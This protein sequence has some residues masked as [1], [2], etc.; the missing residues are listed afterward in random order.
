MNFVRR[1]IA[2]LKR[3]KIKK[4]I[5]IILEIH[6]I[7]SGKGEKIPLLQKRDVKETFQKSKENCLDYI[8]FIEKHQLENEKKQIIPLFEETEDLLYPKQMLDRELEKANKQYDDIYSI[9]N[10]AGEKLL[11]LRRKSVNLIEKVEKLVSSI[12]MSAKKFDKDFEEIKI[13]K[14]KFKGALEYGQEQQKALVRSAR[15]VGTGVTAGIAVA[16]IS[17]KVAMWVATTFGKASTGT[18]I[19]ALS[20]AVAKN[21]A[22]S[23]LGGGAVAAGGGGMVAGKALLALSGPIGWAVSGAS[24]LVSILNLVRKYYNANK[25]KRD[26]IIHMKNYI[27]SLKELK[28]NIDH[29]SKKTAEQLKVVR[30]QCSC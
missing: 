5:G 21:A 15:G 22:L 28:E 10:N 6:K 1:I 11:E 23:W 17:P 2:F 14:N 12:A 16:A 26:E 24:L 7:A 27:E 19:S 25:S 29:I 30:Q 18:A 8:R 9:V 13:H 4:D 20:G 3:L